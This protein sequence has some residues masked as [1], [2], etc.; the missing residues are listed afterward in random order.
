MDTTYTMQDFTN[1]INHS[2]TQ[3]YYKHL[4]QNIVNC[5]CDYT[6]LQRVK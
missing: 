3:Q 6:V 2:G 4:L 1:K 5:I